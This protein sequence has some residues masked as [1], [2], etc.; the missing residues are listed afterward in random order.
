MINPAVGILLEKRDPH[1]ARQEEEHAVRPARPDL[2]DLGGVI[3]L[4]QFGI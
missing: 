1:P 3:G 2:G 4:A